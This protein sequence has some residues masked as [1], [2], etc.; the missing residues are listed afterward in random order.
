[1]SMGQTRL[2]PEE[3]VS[4]RVTPAPTTIWVLEDDVCIVE[5]TRRALYDYWLLSGEETPAARVLIAKAT[6]MVTQVTLG[7]AGESHL[8]ELAAVGRQ[9]TV[10]GIAAAW[11][12]RSS[13][14]HFYNQ[15]LAHVRDGLCPSGE[16]FRSSA[17]PCQHECP[18]NIDIPSFSP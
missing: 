5:K 18:S 7:L 14:S 10:Q 13:L 16:C 3:M 1:M 17:P 11:P 15:W 2:A 4:A 9:M 8:A 12:L 6:R